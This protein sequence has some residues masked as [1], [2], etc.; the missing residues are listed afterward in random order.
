MA[1]SIRIIIVIFSPSQDF[2]IFST[3][4]VITLNITLSISHSPLPLAAGPIRNAE[5]MESLLVIADNVFGLSQNQAVNDIRKRCFENRALNSC[6]FI[7]SKG[8]HSDHVRK[9]L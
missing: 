6:D 4:D 7:L 8:L 9:L 1:F 5:N 2:P 3:C